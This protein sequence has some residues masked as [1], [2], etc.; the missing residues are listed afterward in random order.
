MG[1]HVEY[2]VSPGRLP[3]RGRKKVNGETASPREVWAMVLPVSGGGDDGGGDRADS[4][5]DP[6]EAEHGRT[7]YCDTADSGPVRGGSKT[8]GGTGPKEM[9]GADGD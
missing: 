9:M 5:V 1:P 4:D 3:G 7:I 2:G 6:S 8:A